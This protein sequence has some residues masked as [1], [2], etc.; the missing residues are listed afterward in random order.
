MINSVKVVNYL[1]QS[2]L[3]ELR[4]PERSGFLI[5]NM[6]GI[7]PEKGEIRMTDIVTADGGVYNSARLPT[8]NIIINVRFFSWEGKDVEEIRHESYKWFPIKK[9]VTLT[10]S[11]N[12][13]T[14]TITGY[15]E[16]NE[17]VVFSKE[18]HT[19][20]S[21][22]CPDPYFVDGAGD[23]ITRFYGIEPMFVFP[24][25]NPV[26]EDTLV[27]GE[28]LFSNEELIIYSGDSEVG[29]TMI[30]D[31]V[32]D[33]ANLTIYNVLTREQMVINTDRL[34]AMTGSGIIASDRITIVTM[35][36]QKSI[37]LLRNG[38]E[39]NIL[40]CLDKGANWF[41]L[42]KG[43]NIFAFVAEEGGTN[44]IF[45]IYNKTLYEGV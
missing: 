27:M 36:G 21:I 9:P 4:H 32:G 13:R 2:M 31:A 24:F 7:G 19:Q 17:P 28:M 10:I 42:S 37:T 26:N 39:T 22:I 15:V 23:N 41:Q 45:T 14:A 16:A 3:M 12:S 33:V 40:N 38:V 44:L 8:R 20:L 25:S 30:I 6:T 43:D 18:T 34:K 5:Y 29:I 11:T 35:K 1:G